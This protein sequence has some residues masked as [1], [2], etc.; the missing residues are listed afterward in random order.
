MGVRINK[1]SIFGTN[2]K[3]QRLVC[4][5]FRIHD[6]TFVAVQLPD[7][8]PFAGPGHVTYPPLDL[9]PGTL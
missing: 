5:E 1:C 6:D 8:W 3:Q 2:Q 9:R 4:R 7:S